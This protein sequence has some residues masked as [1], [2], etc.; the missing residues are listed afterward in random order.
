MPEEKTAPRG[1]F[2]GLAGFI[3]LSVVAGV[4]ATAAVTPA[5]AVTGM[6]ANNAIGVFDGLPEFL[7]IGQPMERS[8]VFAADGQVLASFYDQNRVEAKWDE[9]SPYLK[10]AAISTEDPRFFEHGGVDIMGTTRA[11][12][13]TYVIGGDVQGG[14]SITQQ[15]VKNVLIQ[16]CE[17]T[18]TTDE[19]LQACS[20]NATAVDGV[21]GMTRKLKEM[22]YAIGVEK[23]YSKQD[24][25][26]GY[27][28]LANFGGR[29]YGVQTAAN[30]YFNVSAA[31][32]NIQQAATLVAMLNE[33]NGLRVD[34]PDSERNGAAN[35]YAATKIRRDHVIGNMLSEGKITAEEHAA[36]IAA[37]IEPVI[38]PAPTGCGLAGDSGY[39]CDYVQRVVLNAEEF[40]STPEERQATLRRGGLQIHTTLDM[41]LQAASAA[42]VHKYIDTAVPGRDV[43]AAAV[44]VEPGT[45]RITAMAQNTIYTAG[46]NGGDKSYTSLNYSTDYTYGG[47]TGFRTGSAHKVFTLVEWLK[48]GHSLNEPVNG[49][50]R[51]IRRWTDTCQEGGV[52]IQAYNPKNFDGT[53]KGSITPLEATRRS[54]N[55]AYMSMT[56]KL[57]LCKITQ[58]SQ[59]LGIHRADGR[60]MTVVPS[61]T[62]GSANEI[63]P[64][65][66][67]A[68]FAAL[69]AEGRYCKPIA[70]DK[71]VGPDGK[72]LP[73]PSA[74]CTQAV[75]EGVANTANYAMQSIFQ[76]GG[77]AAAAA[78]PGKPIFGKTGTA[79]DAE[80]SW[81]VGGTSKAVTAVW[82][83]SVNG[84]SSMYNTRFKGGYNG[85]ISKL[86][87]WP[88]I[89][90]ASIAK[91]G[92][93]AF[94][95]PSKDLLKQKY[96]T[97]P[98]VNGLSID[99]AKKKLTG[100]GFE[101]VVASAID[102]E[103]AKDRI[104]SSSPGGGAGAAPGSTIT[105]TPSTGSNGKIKT[106]DVVDDSIGDARQTLEGAG[107]SVQLQCTVD[108]ES[109]ED[110]TVVAQNPSAGTSVD[111]QGAVIALAV[112]KQ[113]C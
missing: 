33:P 84:K 29:T 66:M 83:G 26:L 81:L 74:D 56:E 86:R 113:S 17:G 63:A 78:I 35:G 108:P 54:V 111:R 30:Y 27:L 87:I 75:S 100:A 67:A 21:G 85:H 7:A 58:T 77:T 24:I 10:D 72:E 104:V 102:S 99:E 79:D 14:S 91:F 41:D 16:Q 37:P 109:S 73:V 38:T 94:A 93:D 34:N 28:N 49:N 45:G 25:L 55:T 105:I 68:A 69:G 31:D 76:G 92:A 51:E 88:E 20:G 61:Q 50:K 15:Y 112:T 60:P 9:V 62:L 6:T 47:S 65:S 43:G 107:F 70:I 80:H 48:Q 4:L 12:L 22:R 11:I 52:M 82:V 90:R 101:V 64:L 89:T 106:P 46:D 8:T 103:V 32:V 96:V 110:G 1:A 44:T 59:D 18:A 53:A 97:V 3:G 71:V 5:I 36:A 95:G 19:E 23:E 57:D 40:G 98:S 42:S 2:G 13:K 39:F